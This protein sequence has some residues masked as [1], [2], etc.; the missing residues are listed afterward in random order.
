MQEFIQ[1]YKEFKDVELQNYKSLFRDLVEHGQKPKA[2]FIGCSDSRV[3]PNLITKSMPG[4]LFVTRNIGNFV[5]PFEPDNAFHATAAAIE[6]ATEALEVEHI[7]VCGHTHCGAIASLFKDIKPTDTNIH[8]IKWLSLGAEAKQCAE[9][10]MKMASLDIKKEYT[11]QVSVV[12]QLKNL[13]TYPGVK[14]RVEEKKLYLHGWHYNL[15][16]GE[17]LYYSKKDNMFMPLEEAESETV[18]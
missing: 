1:G 10:R 8:T 15:E 2:L 4:E 7:I 9:D 18:N 11:E 13:L 3:V 14:K 17:I 5:P 12:L 16:T 6:Y